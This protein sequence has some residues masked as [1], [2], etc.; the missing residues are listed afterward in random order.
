MAK[1]RFN[2][3]VRDSWNNTTEFTLEAD[4]L[5][6]AVTKACRKVTL[7][8]KATAKRT[9]GKAGEPG[10]HYPYVNAPW[11]FAGNAYHVEPK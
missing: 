3:T 11:P 1:P 9:T 2:V 7:N 8:R 4:D 6:Q 10:W 5:E